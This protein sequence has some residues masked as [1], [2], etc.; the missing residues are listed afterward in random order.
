MKA[1]ERDKALELRIKH[2]LGFGTIAK[3]LSVSKGTL[4]RWLKDYPLS[5][6][7]VLELRR[8][9]WSKSEAK[10]EL[11]RQTMRKKRD[12]RTQKHYLA[13][14]KKFKKLTRQS[15]FVA[16]LMLYLAEGDK[17][18]EYHIGL[19]NTDAELI[20]FFIWW[21]E[22]FLNIS[23][24]KMRGL[25][26]LYEDMN[27]EKERK[28]WVEQT[29]LPRKQFY[30]DQIRPIRPGSFSYPESFRHGTCKIY[31]NGVKEKTELTLSI[32]AFFDTYR[33]LRV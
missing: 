12:A 8:E 28:Y 31:V 33:G 27:L 5:E 11:F 15:L 2:Q 17:K 1:V 18:N 16:G 30:K 25:L 6:K 32:K 3:Q 4:S 19:A 26:H 29:S 21:L 23:K 9:N 14:R 24:S 7:R 22:E 10:R 20:K 13:V